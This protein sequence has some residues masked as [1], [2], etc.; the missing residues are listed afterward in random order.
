MKRHLN[1]PPKGS[2]TRKVFF[3]VI[4]VLGLGMLLAAVLGPILV[5]TGTDPRPWVAVLSAVTYLGFIVTL[6]WFAWMVLRRKPSDGAPA[7]E[8]GRRSEPRQTV[9]RP[10]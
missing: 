4:V 6:A 8:S 5:T 2:P 10:R 1:F 9:K 3:G 7:T